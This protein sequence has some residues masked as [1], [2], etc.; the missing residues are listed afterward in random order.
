MLK[1]ITLHIS[2]FFMYEAT[3]LN[4]YV[5]MHTVN[6]EKGCGY[7]LPHN[8]PIICTHLDCIELL[9]NKDTPK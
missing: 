6:N 2:A 9:Y 8:Y 5:N 3:R 7:F 4:T 1:K